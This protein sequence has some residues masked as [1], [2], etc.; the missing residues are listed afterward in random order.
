V[1][2]LVGGLE[3]P[4]DN[5]SSNHI[6]NSWHAGM[7]GWKKPKGFLQAVSHM[8][9]HGIATQATPRLFAFPLPFSVMLSPCAIFASLLSC[10]ATVP[11]LL[12]PSKESV[13]L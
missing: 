11:S 12:I 9:I 13:L 3:E 5:Q 6:I 4:L 10:H 1:N 2:Q 7:K 8:S